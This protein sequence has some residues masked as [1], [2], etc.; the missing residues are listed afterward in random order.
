MR[1]DKVTWCFKLITKFT[2]TSNTK[3]LTPNTQPFYTSW[4][5]TRLKWIITYRFPLRSSSSPPNSVMHHNY[6]FWIY[7]LHTLMFMF[8]YARGTLI[9]SRLF[10]LM[11]FT[12]CLVP[13]D[14]CQQ[15]NHM[16][17][18]SPVTNFH[19]WNL[20]GH[21]HVAYMILYE[22]FI[23]SCSRGVWL[24][25][26]PRRDGNDLS[27]LGTCK[28]SLQTINTCIVLILDLILLRVKTSSTEQITE[29][30]KLCSFNFSSVPL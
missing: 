23:I 1:W 5:F 29:M 9:V 30:T 13:Y 8:W 3:Y 20:R 2:S 19:I 17:G 7:P 6:P 27:A 18:F 12:L 22:T 14:V 24:Y 28:D 15:I 10:L 4:F 26:Y 21:M 16:Y 11:K 25:S